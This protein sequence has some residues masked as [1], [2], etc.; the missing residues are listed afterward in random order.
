MLSSELQS[1][2]KNPTIW[3]E[4]THAIC[5]ERAQIL[6]RVT[7]PQATASAPV[8]YM[9]THIDTLSLH[10]CSHKPERR[11]SHTFFFFSSPTSTLRTVI[12][13]HMSTQTRTHSYKHD[14]CHS[15]WKPMTAS[16]SNYYRGFV[17]V[18]ECMCVCVLLG[19]WG[20]QS[21]LF[22]VSGDDEA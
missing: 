1:R 22:C 5:L 9:Y 17:R 7:Y 20:V 2:P 11:D 16:G 8:K 12:I 13:T 21:A 15:H 3:L 4:F 18:W 14:P 6:T 19:G 10:M